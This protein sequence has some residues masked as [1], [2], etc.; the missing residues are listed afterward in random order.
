MF[1]VS[2]AA[3]DRPGPLV[4]AGGVL[5]AIVVSSLA[6]SAI[7][8]LAHAAGAPAD[9]A[10]LAPASYIFL[11]ALGVSV[12][13][14]GWAIVR[15]TARDPRALLARL[16]PTVVLLSFVPDFFLLGTGGVTGVAALLAMHITVAVVAVL[17]FHRVMPV[18][19]VR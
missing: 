9:F 6:D 15:R 19:Q 5:A 18:D 7:A 8:I 3:A 4:V 12:G 1:V 10:P 16:A 17:T 2:E 13:A 14:F 11:T